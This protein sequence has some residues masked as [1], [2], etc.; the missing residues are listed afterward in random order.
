VV[1][2]SL[3]LLMVVFRSIAIPGLAIVE[4]IIRAHHGRLSVESS[5]GVVGTTVTV[6]LDAVTP[7]AAVP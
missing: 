3:L 6:E 7:G 5:A 4:A 1:G 2:L